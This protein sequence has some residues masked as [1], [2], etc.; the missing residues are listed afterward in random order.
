MA[1][2]LEWKNLKKIEESQK[3]KTQIREGNEDVTS[4]I[5]TEEEI[6]LC[7][8]EIVIEDYSEIV[9]FT[10]IDLEEE[11]ID[12]ETKIHQIYEF[13]PN[14]LGRELDV[15][16]EMDME[17]FEQAIYSTNMNR[18]KELFFAEDYEFEIIGEAGDRTA[19]VVFKRAKGEI[20][21]KKVCGPG[22]KLKGK[23]CIPQTG[24]QKAKEKKK[25]IKLKRAKRAMG[26]GAKKK[27]AIQAKI[28]KRRTQSKA[29]NFS[30]T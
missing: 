22:M 19:K 2:L 4:L 16:C 25:G 27:A 29:R 9:E 10:D 7:K 17:V 8:E 18:I 6:E 23:K 21:K 24:T 3:V 5:L 15:V 11:T 20:S 12:E 13:V 28:T 26:G 30:G 1:T 14:A